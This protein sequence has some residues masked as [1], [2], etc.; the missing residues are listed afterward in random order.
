MYLL[1]DD[2]WHK[3]TEDFGTV[4]EH[5]TLLSAVDSPGAN[6]S[7]APD[8]ILS[9]I[10]QSASPTWV[11][12]SL[13]IRYH[14]LWCSVWYIIWCCKRLKSFCGLFLDV[15]NT[16][17]VPFFSTFQSSWNSQGEYL[18]A[19]LHK[20]ELKL[21]SGLKIPGEERVNRKIQCDCLC[22]GN[23]TSTFPSSFCSSGVRGI[24]EDLELWL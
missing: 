13:Q 6:T 17:F 19:L 12:N 15:N 3:L 1:V 21:A 7:W 5:R 8:V 24:W 9:Y 4:K 18:R 14:C 20:S 10:D 2:K 22:L 16:V 23:Y 11:T